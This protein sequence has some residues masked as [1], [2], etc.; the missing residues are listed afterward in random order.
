MWTGLAQL[1]LD[2]LCLVL[3]A[4]AAVDSVSSKAFIATSAVSLV[5]SVVMIGD[6]LRRRIDR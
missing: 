5:V 4:C 3:A 6:S 2:V 1:M